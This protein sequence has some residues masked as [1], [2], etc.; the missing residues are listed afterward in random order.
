MN[1]GLSEGVRPMGYQRNGKLGLGIGILTTI[2]GVL[3]SQRETARQ[4]NKKRD[5]RRLCEADLLSQE[6]W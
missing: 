5:G 4:P 1:N 6:T 2:F 3:A